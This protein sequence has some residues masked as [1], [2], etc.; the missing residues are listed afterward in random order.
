MF[1]FRREK[2]SAEQAT[3]ALLPLFVFY[4]L[5]RTGGQEQPAIPILE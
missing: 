1:A 4:D 3:F 2:L 5:P